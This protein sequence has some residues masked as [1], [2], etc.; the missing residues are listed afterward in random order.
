[1][2]TADKRLSPVLLTAGAVVLGSVF[3]VC[4]GVGTF[5]MLWLFDSKGKQPRI[6]SH[7]NGGTVGAIEAV[8]EPV[9]NSIPR[10]EVDPSVTDIRFGQWSKHP[11]DEH[12][13][14]ADVTARDK[15][16]T[17]FWY[18]ADQYDRTNR[19]LETFGISF[20]RLEPSETGT[21]R[22]RVT[23]GAVRIVIRTNKRS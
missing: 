23:P 14:S 1:M 13:I 16:A 15:K 11:T 18:Q 9:A 3:F 5:G 20:P 22:I 7:E 12:Y 21:A 19:K 6:T 4:A 10:V 2:G 8:E 17:D